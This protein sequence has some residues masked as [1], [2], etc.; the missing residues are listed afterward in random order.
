[1]NFVRLVAGRNS[2]STFTANASADKSI[3]AIGLSLKYAM[4]YRL[5]RHLVSQSGQLAINHSNIANAQLSGVYQQLGWLRLTFSAAGVWHW[6]HSELRRSAVLSQWL[7]EV[8]L[9]VFPTKKIGLKLKWQNQTHEVQ[10]SRFKG[11]NLFDM[12][13]QWRISK[14]WELGLAASNLLDARSYVVTSQSGL[15]TFQSM[16]PLRGREVMLRLLWRM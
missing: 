9:H 8:S 13:A 5:M 11:I 16:L 2:S 7:G 10:P 1:M 15:D 4:G 14:A 6:E 12:D 3:T